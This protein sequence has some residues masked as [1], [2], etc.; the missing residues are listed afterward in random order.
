M[1]SNT[2]MQSFHMSLDS[3]FHMIPISHS[4]KMKPRVRDELAEVHLA[5]HR[6]SDTFC[7]LPGLYSQGKHVHVHLKRKDPV[8]R[9]GAT[10]FS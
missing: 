10:D 5:K 7:V 6:V 2:L 4:E 3:F 8:S 1:H 9:A